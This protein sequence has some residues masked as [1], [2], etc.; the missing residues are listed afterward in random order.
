[1]MWID[2]AIVI[3]FMPMPNLSLLMISGYACSD[4]MSMPCS[5]GFFAMVV[6][7]LNKWHISNLQLNFLLFFA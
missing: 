4:I 5:L 3:N 1:M 2:G 7:Q 6:L